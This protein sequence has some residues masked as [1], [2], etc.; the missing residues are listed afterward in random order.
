MFFQNLIFISLLGLSSSAGEEKREVTC[1][2]CE[3]KRA[4]GS[5]CS[6]DFEAESFLRALLPKDFPRTHSKL[7]NNLTESYKIPAG[8]IE[9]LFPHGQSQNT[10]V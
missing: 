8:E 2:I 9:K 1:R 5:K 3:K 6:C 10:E 7:Q 4:V